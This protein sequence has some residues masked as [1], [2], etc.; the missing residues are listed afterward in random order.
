MIIIKS[1][2]DIDKLIETMKRL[3]TGAPALVILPAS[4]AQDTRWLL[5]AMS[6]GP[7]S[8]VFTPTDYVWLTDDNF[9]GDLTG[10]AQVGSWAG[11]TCATT[12]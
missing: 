3:P 6:M 9:D 1:S 2:G 8:V 11:S 12:N 5:Y 10:I 4:C 7:G